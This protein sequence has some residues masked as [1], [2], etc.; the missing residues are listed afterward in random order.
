MVTPVSGSEEHF[1]EIAGEYDESLPPH[2]VEHYLAK[3]VAFIG[4][5]L[6]S[7]DVLDAGC[8]TGVVASRLAD[9]GYSVTGLD[10]SAGMLRFLEE[11]DQRVTA[12]HGS[13]TDMPFEDGSFD[14]TYCV[15][16][17]HHIA[18]P[19]L[20]HQA[21]GEMVRVTRPG[22]LILV[23]DHN[24]RNP[25][26]KNLMARVPQDDGSER[27]IPEAEVTGGLVGGG[28]VI[29][30]SDQLGLVPDFVPPALLGA[31]AVTE[32]AVERIPGLRR[33]CAHNVVVARR[34]GSSSE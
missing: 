9:D 1:D 19:D 8:G 30:T 32:K 2:V 29:E 27:L 4:R 10:P 3:R 13:A 18:A 17:M 15:A 24:P 33:L 6:D 34:A 11:R 25:Y 16:V 5:L 12:V 7:G 14:L 20:V 28:A 31:S 26:W 21:L 22:G 23:W